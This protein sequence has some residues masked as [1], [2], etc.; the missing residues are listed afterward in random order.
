MLKSAIYSNVFLLLIIAVVFVIKIFKSR[1]NE[2]K[3]KLIVIIC[4]LVNFI[5]LYMMKFISSGLDGIVLGPISL[6]TFIIDIISFCHLRKKTKNVA[7]NY[8]KNLSIKKYIILCIIPI[9]IILIPF[10][11]ELYIINNCNYLLHYNYQE[12]FIRSDDTYIAIINNKP[13]KIALQEN[14]FNRNGIIINEINYEVIFSDNIKIT[15]RDSNYNKIIVENADIKKIALDA[16]R[17]CPLAKGAD[18]VYLPGDKYAIIKLT[19]EETHGT[20]LEEYFYYKGSYIK[21]L[22]TYGNLESIVYYN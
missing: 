9:I 16:K 8:S 5:N 14:L 13:V 2:K 20:I 4:M 22:H 21:K 7:D 12:G 15:T 6:I 19:D 1:I 10:G 17:R 11:Y 18:I 3:L